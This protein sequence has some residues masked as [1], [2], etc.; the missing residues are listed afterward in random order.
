MENMRRWINYDWFKLIVTLILLVILILLLLVKPVKVVSETLPSPVAT[1]AILAAA[2]P[3]ASPTLPQPTATSIPPTETS[4]PTPTLAP[5]PTAQ[6]TAVPTQESTPTPPAAQPTPAPQTASGDCSKALPTRLDV[7]KKAQVIFNLY[8]RKE[9]GMDKTI[10]F[11][12]LPGNRL[13]IIGGPV[14]I[15]YGAGVYRWWNVKAVTGDAGWSA[16][17]SLTGKDYFLDPV[18]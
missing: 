1:A 17:G 12:S 10:I 14:C 9:P 8:L 16:E 4:Q 6:P 18:P 11:T 13:E 5:S 15:P 2:I 7:G 3:T